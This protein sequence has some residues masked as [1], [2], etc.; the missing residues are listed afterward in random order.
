MSTKELYTKGARVWI[1]HPELVWEGAEVV[2]DYVS[3]ILKV[4]TEDGKIKTLDVGS[5][6][7]LPHLRNPDI[8]IGENDLTSLSYLHEPAVLYNLQ[9]RFC[10]QNA[11]YTY[12]GIV[13][14]A[15]N[16]YTDLPIYGPDTI[17]AYRGQA[18]G[19]LDPHIFAVAEEAYTKMEREQRDQ[20]II[21]SG[22][23]GAGKT[24]S[25]KYAM[26]YFATVGGSTTETHVE[27]K[28]LASSP[29]MEAIG[30]AK[31]TRNDNSSRFGKFIELQ[32]SRTYNIIGASMRTYLLE[33]SRVV[34][35][36]PEER[37]YHI[38]YQLCA[39]REQYPDLHLGEAKAYRYLNKEAE[40]PGVD[41]SQCFQETISALDTLGFSERKISDIFKVLASI[42]HLGNI[43]ICGASDMDDS[44]ISASDVHLRAFAELLG[45]NVDQFRKWLCQRRIVSR[46]ESFE[47]PMTL[48]EASGARDALAKYIYAELFSWIVEVINRSLETSSGA[49][50][51][52]IGVLDI[53]GFE[54]FEINSFEQF[55]INYANEK[56]QQQFNQ[57]VFKLEQE[58]YLKEDIEWKF[59]DFCD[60]Q[61]CIDLIETKLG[62]LDLL[63][64]ECRMPKGTDNSWV[65][66]LCATCT[67]WPHFTKP[68]FGN[69]AFVIRHFADKVEYEATGFLEKNRDTVIEEQVE[70]LR[71]GDNRLVRHLFRDENRL[72]PPTSIGT[73]TPRTRVTLTSQKSV[74]SAG[75]SKNKKTVGSQFRSSL[76]ALMST[77]NATTPH[78]I[79]CIKPNDNKQPFEYNSTRAVQQLRACGVL[80]TIRISAAGFPSRWPY[81]DFFNRYRV[82]CRSKDI[83][84]DNLRAT[85]E[86]ILVNFIKDSDK[87]KFGKTKIFFRA[88]Q[89][90]YLERLRSERLKHCC[91][92][93][94]K[95]VRGFLQ[96]NR[97][98]RVSRAVLTL[99]RVTRGFIAR[100]RVKEIR[101]NHAAKQIQ[102]YV[103]GWVKRVQYLRMKRLAVGLQARVRGLLARRRFLEYKYNHAALVIQ[104]NTR[105]WIC[106]KRYKESMRKLIVA[107][108][109]VRR[110]LARRKLKELKK[111][112]RTV[113]HHITLNKGLE[114]KIIQLQQQIGEL[115]KENNSLKL[116]NNE[117]VETR[118]K[119]E[120]LRGADV[121]L[122]K[123]TAELNE[124]E[125]KLLEATSELERE[126]GEKVDLITEKE[127]LLNEYNA[128][129]TRYS[130]DIN[131]LKEQVDELNEKIKSNQISAE[132]LLKYRLDTEKQQLLLEADKD[133]NNYQK[134][135]C[136]KNDLEA[137][138]DMLER[139]LIK[140]KG[141]KVTNLH[142]RSLSDSSGLSQIDDSMITLINE[143]PEEDFGYGSVRS[144]SSRSTDRGSDWSSQTTPESTINRS[145]SAAA[146]NIPQPDIQP[147]DVSLVLK[148]QQKLKS[149]ESER[150]RL[151][152]RLED[153][154]DGPAEQKAQD[155]FKL[156]QLEMENSKLKADLTS[157]RK[158]VA[159]N[160]PG[161]S[162]DELMKQFMTQEK[163]LVRLGDECVQLRG[164]LAN[165][166]Q[167]LR[168]IATSNYAAQDMDMSLINEDGELVLA[169]EAQKKINRQLEDE[170]QTCQMR[171]NVEREELVE[172]L[173]RLREDNERQQRLLSAN[174]TKGP[175]SQNEAFLQHEIKRLTQENL[176]LQDKHDQIADEYRRLKKMY[177]DLHRRMK[178]AGMSDLVG[179]QVPAIAEQTA[180]SKPIVRKKERIYNGM[181]EFKKGDE[182]VIIRHLLWDLKPQIA[183]TLLPGL[184]AYIL[185]MCVRHTDFIND[186]EKVR[187][188]LAGFINTVKKVIRKRQDDIETT[189]MWLGNTLRMLHNLKQYSGE[190]TFKEENT[191][192]QNEQCL[193]NFDLSE[194]RQVLSDLAIWIYMAVIRYMEQKLQHKAVPAILEHEAITGL[195][196]GMRGRA[197][198]VS[199]AAPIPAQQALDSLLQELTGFHRTLI[200]HGVDQEII[201][202]VFR[203]IFYYICASSLNNL[204]LRRD[205]CHWG[206]GMNIRYNL[207]HIEQWARD[208]KLNDPSILECL[209]P[210]IQAA[211]LLQARKYD[212]D[213]NNVCEMCMKMSVPQI[214]KLLNLYTPADDYEERVP[215]SFIRKVQQRLKERAGDQ[216]T[217]LMD[218]KFNFPVRF[219]FKPSPIQLEEIEI[220]EVLNLPMLNKV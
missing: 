104:K 113:Q 22:E 168:S 98:L 90:A 203:Q 204:L 82:L 191:A 122:K 91:I 88:G 151:H 132:E 211:Q 103:R 128:E 77:L 23:S 218:T 93:M 83:K 26:R 197:A 135:L 67:K 130:S 114:N 178:D 174:L 117:L 175:Q 78:Y 10:N 68:R 144:A 208:Q 210:I 64:E 196:N 184:P 5:E 71:S 213:V 153:K 89:L 219:P 179:P 16:P 87:F 116:V 110:F 65:E 32:F 127:A 79:R 167:G 159:D 150:D 20:S 49:R 96:R 194:Y 152:R 183:V 97:Y 60:N 143:M 17:H 50:H 109:A 19:D 75:P 181:F 185:F 160:V 41:D 148:L 111:E 31:T 198:S 54:T 200:L 53:Y 173:K 33:K 134:V 131:M 192:T 112:A 149:V 57:H 220:P 199:D 193:R 24:V 125:K 52:F 164:V 186:E 55:C 105:A 46:N 157:L 141:G 81:L 44:S 43:Q 147:V 129:K 138:C 158:T 202:Q 146:T 171:W 35:Q 201:V 124:K 212:E 76:N 47:K 163:E 161:K 139:E 48:F 119:L 84:R 40:I 15:I 25:A 107:Q 188:L 39:G 27:K 14:V 145:K 154:D 34:F 28:V 177:K 11:I 155:N 118:A 94:Q 51:K 99:Q 166:T 182:P 6:E 140:L 21:V 101:R 74:T 156:Q 72:A 172:E 61:P 142:N 58:E 176:D 37:N 133:L 9:V 7:N 29:I 121:E 8:L 207:S 195:S 63:D 1:P 115:T 108:N 189:V 102:R 62:I 73:P 45:V 18:M 209:Q 165:Q 92:V 38:L 42:L 56:L 162:A 205:L 180:Y 36:A 106:R 69:S 70:A 126:K 100:R 86:C 66:K 170:L 13:L 137:R 59:I 2:E 4:K 120:A 95:T 217:L 136:E 80:E 216:V 85:C 30:N 3:K 206:K 214:V 190:K 123:R 187:D 215:L 12:C 169:F